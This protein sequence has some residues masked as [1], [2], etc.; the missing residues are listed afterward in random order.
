LISPYKNPQVFVKS[1]DDTEGQIH[2]FSRLFPSF[3]VFRRCP[4]LRPL[5]KR[6][7][8]SMKIC[9]SHENIPLIFSRYRGFPY[10]GGFHTWGYPI[11]GWFITENPWLRWMIWGYPIYGPPHINPE[12]LL[13]I[14]PYYN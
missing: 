2:H 4:D 13:K 6:E 12:Y 9:H 11:A 3:S 1:L 8:R 14:Y 5:R 7:A 10:M